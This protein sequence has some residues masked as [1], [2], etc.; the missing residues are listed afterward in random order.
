[1]RDVFSQ[2]GA[3]MT[4]GE[5]RYCKGTGFLKMHVAE[6]GGTIGTKRVRCHHI[7]GDPFG[8]EGVKFA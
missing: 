4:K 7:V 5:C 1:M 6:A 3:R 2:H 8:K